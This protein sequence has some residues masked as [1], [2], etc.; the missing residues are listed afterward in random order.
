M[1]T[2]NQIAGS[3]VIPALRYHDA[4]AAID[5][6]C[7][8]FGFERRAVYTNNDN[9]VMHAELTLGN[10]MI[11]LGSVD[12]KTPYSALIRQPRDVGF[13][14][15]SPYLVVADCPAVYERAK[16]AGAEI[17]MELEEK[18][19]GGKGFN[20]RD[21]EGHMWSVGEYDPWAQAAQSQ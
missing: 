9:I 12:N 4:L 11:M 5:W 7:R 21:L 18:S 6:L 17:V 19:Y 8:V 15:Q 20:C 10:G 2:T 1:T 14:T 13:E 3:S 16:A